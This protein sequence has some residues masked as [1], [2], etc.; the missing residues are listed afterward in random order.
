MSDGLP[1]SLERQSS[2]SPALEQESMIC[3]KKVTELK[4]KRWK[5][6]QIS[7]TFT[8]LMS[9]KHTST[10]DGPDSEESENETD[11]HGRWEAISTFG[12]SAR[13]NF[14]LQLFTRKFSYW[15]HNPEM[16]FVIFEGTC[17]WSIFYFLKKEGFNIHTSPMKSGNR[18][19]ILLVGAD[20]SVPC[21][22]AIFD[23]G[24]W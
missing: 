12:T 11:L 20:I 8:S 9:A 4:N 18:S 22:T 6:P 16:L 7:R 19:R 21:I 23:K 2:H 3:L 13:G 24:T 5:V 10:E 14:M 17:A 1:V 15:I